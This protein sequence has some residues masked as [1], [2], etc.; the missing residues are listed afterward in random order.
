M[1]RMELCSVE[2]GGP[3]A[4]CEIVVEEDLPSTVAE[5]SHDRASFPLDYQEKS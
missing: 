2:V 3:D 5:L 1:G 4:L